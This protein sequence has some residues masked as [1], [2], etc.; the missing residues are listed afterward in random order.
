M[1]SHAEVVIIGGGL[2]GCE[3]AEF[4]VESGK[5]VTIIEILPEMATDVGPLHR[6]LLLDRLNIKK[7]TM[8]T[9]VRDEEV[10]DKGLLITTKES[11][12]RT[13]K[14]DTIV[15]ATGARPNTE[16]SKAL[17]DKGYETHLIGDCIEPRRILD[18]IH[19]GFAVSRT[20]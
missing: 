4:L 8:L 14:A 16:L 9:G 1:R 15:L 10:I 12:K 11:E 6:G 19:D 3:T 17:K 2:V 18:A 20:I 7:V 13:I 5:K